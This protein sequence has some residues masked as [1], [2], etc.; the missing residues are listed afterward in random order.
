[1]ARGRQSCFVIIPQHV[2]SSYSNHFI[3]YSPSSDLLSAL[4]AQAVLFV[5]YQSVMPAATSFLSK[6]V[7]AGGG[8][9]PRSSTNDARG[10]S[11]GSSPTRN[12]SR[13]LSASAMTSS[14]RNSLL[15]DGVGPDVLVVPPSPSEPSMPSDSGT[16]GDDDGGN[17]T[18]GRRAVTLTV[19]TPGDAN[20]NGSRSGLGRDTLIELT[21]E[22]TPTP[23]HPMHG[24]GSPRLL[25]HSSSSPDIAS[26]TARTPK[27]PAH[28]RYATEAP[29]MPPPPQIS[30]SPD[31]ESGR[32]L[33]GAMAPIVESPTA[34]R[35][36]FNHSQPFVLSS[37]R[38]STLL[39]APADDDGASVYSATTGR[40]KRPWNRSRS[41]EPMVVP[42]GAIVASPPSSPKGRRR[43]ERKPTGLAAAIAASGMA[44]AH[45]ALSMPTVQ[46]SLS[47]PSG[48]QQ[49]G[50]SPRRSGSL[51]STNRHAIAMAHAPRA[52]MEMSPT[53]E[54]RSRATSI[55][56]GGDATGRSA[57]AS[58]YDSA[59][60]SATDDSDGELDLSDDI[61]V[62][63]F[64]VASTKRNADFHDMFPDIPKEDYL[65]EGESYS[66]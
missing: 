19:S 42:P 3:P 64:A 34:E 62:T 11:R 43:G 61:P 38:S 23:N 30:L 54:S 28:G 16:G 24:R 44:V 4:L 26:T 63:G 60:T 20:D 29:P 6:F 14:S 7:K 15:S 1:V 5:D 57:P 37:D 58:E 2:L 41:R 47:A 22:L 66:L 13:T 10:S 56:E 9:S 50:R 33:H 25:R 12:R 59:S 45:P 21:P 39:A 32:S 49:A 52:S 31:S 40:K 51:S 36:S 55:S 8:A 18:R 46:A 65:I 35:T 53:R 48:T 17:R 27:G